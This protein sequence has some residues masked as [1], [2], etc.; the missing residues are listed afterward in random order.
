MKMSYTYTV[1]FYL[2]EKQKD[3]SVLF[4]FRNIDPN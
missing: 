1:E 3:R 2:V 4:Y